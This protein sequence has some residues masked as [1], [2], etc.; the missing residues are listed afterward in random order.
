M[1][2]RP[3]NIFKKEIIIFFSAIGLFLFSGFFSGFFFWLIFPLAGSFWGI[4]FYFLNVKTFQS[5]LI[6]GKIV[7]I[8]CVAFSLALFIP[9]SILKILPEE[10]L[11]SLKNS[12]GY[13]P[14]SLIGAFSF[15]IL[16]K[17]FI[18][19]SYFKWFYIILILNAFLSGYIWNWIYANFSYIFNTD[20]YTT[21]FCFI[22]WHIIMG[23]TFNY[24]LKKTF[25]TDLA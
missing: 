11:A 17:Y 10:Y 19:W 1:E 5:Q 23:L 22:E 6:L 15:Y 16:S 2:K 9:P 12:V 7:I 21:Y 4:A 8:S 20:S 13:I 14:S 25:K 24:G 18:K 3:I